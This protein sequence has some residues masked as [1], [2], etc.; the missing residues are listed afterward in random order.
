MMGVVFLMILAQQQAK[1]KFIQSDCFCLQWRKLPLSIVSHLAK[2][3]RK[4]LNLFVLH[5]DILPFKS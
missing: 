3:L 4:V 1:V 5:V 2:K